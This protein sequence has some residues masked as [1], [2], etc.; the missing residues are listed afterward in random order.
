MKKTIAQ[1]VARCA[2]GMVCASLLVG[3][4][5][6]HAQTGNYPNKPIRLVI[7]FPPGGAT[8]IIGR[9]LALKLST[10]LGQQVVVDNKPGAGGVIGADIAAK[11]APDGY[12]LVLGQDGNIVIGPAVRSKQLYN[13]LTDF[14]PISLVVRTP[15]VIVVNPTQVPVS[16]LKGLLAALRAKLPASVAV[17]VGGRHPMLARRPVPGV[18]VLGDLSALQEA[19]LRW[20]QGRLAP[21]RAVPSPEGD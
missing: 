10:A 16:D 6:P 14:T 12:N 15:Q 21:A 2:Q 20:R 5:L 7:P 13:P 17:W 19:L 11:A 8:D 9:S 18:T 4:S 1:W 3:A